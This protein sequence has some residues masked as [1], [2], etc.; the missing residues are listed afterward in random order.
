MNTN[1]FDQN[2]DLGV[3]SEADM[4]AL[5]ETLNMIEPGNGQDALQSIGTFPFYEYSLIAVLLVL[6]FIT[7]NQILH[8]TSLGEFVRV[9][10]ML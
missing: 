2:Y 7:L 8:K 10:L 5:S 3:M 6:G 1:L 9:K 4:L